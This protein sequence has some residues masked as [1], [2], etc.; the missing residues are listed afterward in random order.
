MI[1]A[2]TLLA[3]CDTAPAAAILI[4]PPLSTT[5]AGGAISV[6]VRVT[7][8]TD[9]YAYQFNLSF[10]PAVLSTMGVREGAFLSGVGPTF[11]FP[12][13]ADNL[14]GTVTLTAGSLEG[15]VPGVTGSGSLATIQFT[16]VG[17]GAS[18]VTLSNVVLLDSMGRDI[19]TIIQNGSV[20]VVPE[21][22][23]VLLLGYGLLGGVIAR[24]CR[25]SLHRR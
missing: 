1:W 14:S 17:L 9:L 10:N 18:P 12:G 15:P 22:A 16:G 6:A 24:A 19:A 11:F 5:P 4:E 7:G 21:P 23:A 3:F 13:T 2:V 25:G 20:T 8:V